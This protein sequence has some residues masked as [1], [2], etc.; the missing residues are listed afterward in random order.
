MR[1]HKIPG[2]FELDQYP[3]FEETPVSVPFALYVL[4][5]IPTAPNLT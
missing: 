5:K 4:L 3:G 1:F 2:N